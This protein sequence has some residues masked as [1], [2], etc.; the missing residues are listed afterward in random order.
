[1]Y[2]S[3]HPHDQNCIRRPR[4]PA[5]ETS[6]SS[7]GESQQQSTCLSV[8]AALWD[9]KC[10]LSLRCLFKVAAVSHTRRQGWP[11]RAQQDFRRL[12]NCMFRAS[13]PVS[14][15]VWFLLI[16]LSLFCWHLCILSVCYAFDTLV[17]FVNLEI[18]FI[19]QMWQRHLRVVRG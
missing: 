17:I 14:A 5:R 11:G 10:R 9:Q 2:A 18:S 1:M 8:Q 3:C 4:A 16:F 7:R 13:C 6:G 12:R 15:T 19:L